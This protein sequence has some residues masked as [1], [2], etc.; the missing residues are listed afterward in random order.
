MTTAMM[1]ITTKITAAATRR[2]N[3]ADCQRRGRMWRPWLPALPVLGPDQPQLT[4]PDDDHDDEQDDPVQRAGTELAL[5]EARL[6]NEE[7][8]GG[9]AEAGPAAGHHEDEAEQGRERADHRDDEGELDEPGEQ[10]ERHPVEDLPPVQAVDPG[11]LDQGRVERG[12][13]GQED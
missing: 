4:D 13:A 5:G 6:V 11:R 2:R 9:G 10:R 1:T 3:R 12:H 8:Q 7:L